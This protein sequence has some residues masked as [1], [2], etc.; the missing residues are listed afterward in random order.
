M[1]FTS[2]MKIISMNKIYLYAH[3]TLR[4]IYQPLKKKQIPFIKIDELS[5][6][7]KVNDSKKCNIN[8][9]IKS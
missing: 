4:I 2:L 8:Q 5:H 1:I 3:K 9:E 7:E 6:L